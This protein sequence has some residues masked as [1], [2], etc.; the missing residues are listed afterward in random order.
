MVRMS[1]VGSIAQIVELHTLNNDLAVKAERK[2]MSWK[3]VFNSAN[4]L[5]KTICDIAKLAHESGYDFFTFNGEVYFYV[6]GRI[7]K[8]KLK[9]SDL[10]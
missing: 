5:G 7:H 3:F 2:T 9:T 4:L 8:T 10:I 6:E 1:Q